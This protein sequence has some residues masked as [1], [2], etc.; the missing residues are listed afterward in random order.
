MRSLIGLTRPSAEDCNRLIVEK[1][2]CS[3]WKTVDALRR[4]DKRGHDEKYVTLLFS[5]IID[6][7]AFIRTEV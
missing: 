7:L 2:D 3:E 1:L 6:A 4:R 5:F